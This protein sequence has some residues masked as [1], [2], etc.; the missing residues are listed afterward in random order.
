MNDFEAPVFT[1]I[2][3]AKE[4]AFLHEFVAEFL[5]AVAENRCTILGHQLDG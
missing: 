4:R 1:Q 3:K 2:L 5:T